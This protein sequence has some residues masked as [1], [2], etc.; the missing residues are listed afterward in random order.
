MLTMNRTLDEKIGNIDRVYLTDNDLFH[1]ERFASN[2][3]AR[4]EAYN[5]LRDRADELVVR[6]LKLLAQQYPDLVQKH[7]QRCKYDMSH[8]LR[9]MAL[10]IL[11]DDEAFFKDSLMD[12][13]ANIIHSYQMSS[14]CSTAYR[15]LQEVAGQMLSP[16]SSSLVKPYLEIAV[17]TFTNV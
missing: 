8:I 14:E 10:A 17:S 2:F 16:Q 5:L 6:S 1:L 11:R 12:W 9:Y 4:L 15:L 13:H 3:S 7:L